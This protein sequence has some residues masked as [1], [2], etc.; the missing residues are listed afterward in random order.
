LCSADYHHNYETDEDEKAISR[1]KEKRAMGTNRVKRTKEC[2]GCGNIV[3]ISTKECRSCDYQ[4]T[5]K[6]LLTGL[7]S[8]TQESNNIREL[9]PFEPER[10]RANYCIGI[11]SIHL[12]SHILFLG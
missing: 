4:F 9:F 7:Q 1:E 10:V 11:S 3:A 12:D 5:S 2:P 6:S 8:A